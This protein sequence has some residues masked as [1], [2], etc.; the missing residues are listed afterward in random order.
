M[1][2]P[3]ALAFEAQNGNIFDIAD[4]SPEIRSGYACLADSIRSHRGNVTPTSGYRP[5]QYQS[6]LKEIWQKLDS[7]KTFQIPECADR[8]QKISNEAAK[9]QILGLNTSPAGPSGNHTQGLAVDLNWGPNKYVSTLPDG[10]LIDD[11]ARACG[12]NRRL[13][14]DPIHFEVLK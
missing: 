3:L 1:T 4:T 7:L 11:L 5:P 8:M 14:A 9:H 12:L 2:D 6:H 10:A 13:P